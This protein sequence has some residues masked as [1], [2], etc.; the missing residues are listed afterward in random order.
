MRKRAN[1][2]KEYVQDFN[3]CLV[4]PQEFYDHYQD[5]KRNKSFEVTGLL[6][7]ANIF[8][9]NPNGKPSIAVITD[10]L[11]D[12][13]VIHTNVS[14]TELEYLRP[15]RFQNPN[16]IIT[17]N[18]DFGIST[19]QQYFISMDMVVDVLKDSDFIFAVEPAQSEWLKN[20]TGRDVT[21]MPH[22]TDIDAVYRH[23]LEPDKDRSMV[24][25]DNTIPTVAVQWRQYENNH[26]LPF[27][28]INNMKRRYQKILFGV[29][30]RICIKENY[31]FP[32]QGI[33][34][35]SSTGKPDP[36]LQKLC[37]PHPQGW[38]LVFPFLKPRDFYGVLGNCNIGLDLRTT[39]SY[40]RF[41][42]DCAMVGIPCVTSMAC[43][44]GLRLFPDIQCDIS[45]PT[46]IADTITK[47]TTSPSHYNH[48][49]SYAKNHLQYYSMDKC[50]ERYLDMI[51]MSSG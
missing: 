48:T 26:I 11:T 27:E 10:D 8:S 38:D 5:T 34:I 6:N 45:E 1:K 39:L 29:K 47:L 35:N 32:T 33:P 40:A 49:V 9:N 2:K 46:T 44:S 15:I 14:S 37:I 19:W 16:A 12:Y 17:T 22:P 24:N 25:I 51:G 18:L 36:E 21:F 3:F 7:W 42:I 20:M 31:N 43:D 28:I 4:V 50:R 23:I 30:P 13:D 41:P